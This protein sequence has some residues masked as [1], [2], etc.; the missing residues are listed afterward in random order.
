M[1]IRSSLKN[2]NVIG[3]SWQEYYVLTC[4]DATSN[5]KIDFLFAIFYFCDFNNKYILVYVWRQMLLVPNSVKLSRT[6]TYVGNLG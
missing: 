3:I 1:L 6:M 5:N 2:K 4:C